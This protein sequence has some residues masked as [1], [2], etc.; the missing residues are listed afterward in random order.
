[1]ESKVLLHPLWKHLQALQQKSFR[2]SQHTFSLPV[3][4]GNGYITTAVLKEILRELDDTL[5]NDDL[6]AMIEGML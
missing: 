3:V 5:T 2:C 1:M 4:A 6:D